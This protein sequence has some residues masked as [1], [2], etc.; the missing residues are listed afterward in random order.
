MDVIYM[1]T[2]AKHGRLVKSSITA[3]KAAFLELDKDG[4][5]FIRLYM[6]SSNG[7]KA[8]ETCRS[9][10]RSI[11]STISNRKLVTWSVSGKKEYVYFK[12]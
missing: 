5:S 8:S 11:A 2:C 1:Y 6:T 12:G 10:S 3:Q 9:S 4:L 7:L